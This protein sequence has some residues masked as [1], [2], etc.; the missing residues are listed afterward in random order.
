MA[1][2]KT[3]ADMTGQ[4]TMH[5]PAAEAQKLT[6]YKQDSG[7]CQVAGPHVVSCLKCF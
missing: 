5:A 6:G 7:V 3:L 4:L 1:A 2:V